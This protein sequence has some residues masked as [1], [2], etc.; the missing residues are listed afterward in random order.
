MNN[1]LWGVP[2]ALG[3]CIWLIRNRCSQMDLNATLIV[4]W[5]FMFTNKCDSIWRQIVC[6]KS[7]IDPNRLLLFL[8]RPAIKS[9]L[10]S[11]IGST[12]DRNPNASEIVQQEF[13]VIIDNGLNVDF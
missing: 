5:I 11:L 2:I 9:L 6:A 10:L 3:S 12:L 7:G 4:K 13:S 1:F 8:D